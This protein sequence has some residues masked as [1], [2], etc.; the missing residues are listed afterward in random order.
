ML[1]VGL[2]PAAHL[3]FQIE[4][5]LLEELFGGHPCLIGTNQNGEVFGHMTVFN[6][7]DADFFQ[8]F[9]K[10]RH[11]WSFVELTAEF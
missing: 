7:L 5:H 4:T 2:L 6:C 9:C 8:R 11:V 1:A 10:T 3:V